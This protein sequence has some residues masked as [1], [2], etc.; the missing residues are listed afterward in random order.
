MKKLDTNAVEKTFA[1]E[2]TLTQWVNRVV[3]SRPGLTGCLDAVAIDGKTIRAT[4][5]SG[6]TTSNLLSVVSHE[7]S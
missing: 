7:Y 2:K 6:G 1:V 4:Q 5:K 3:Q